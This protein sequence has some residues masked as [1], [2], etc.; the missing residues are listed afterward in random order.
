MRPLAIWAMQ[1]ALSRTKQVHPESKSDEKEDAL[2]NYHD[3]GF[4]RVAHLLK[5]QEEASPRSLLQVIFDYTCK[6]MI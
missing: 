2:F 4:T 1:W 6:R 3:D 5:V